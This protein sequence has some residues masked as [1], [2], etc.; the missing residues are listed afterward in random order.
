MR[1]GKRTSLKFVV[2]SGKTPVGHVSEGVLLQTSAAPEATLM[3]SGTGSRKGVVGLGGGGPGRSYIGGPLTRGRKAPLQVGRSHGKSRG[4]K[5]RQAR[6]RPDRGM[7]VLQGGASGCEL[8]VIR[9]RYKP[10]L[11]F[12]FLMF[13]RTWGGP[14]GTRTLLGLPTPFNREE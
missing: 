3:I 1:G 12:A 5:K 7:S 9:A 10:F 8:R 13:L 14:S 2:S 11:Q 6:V 4:E